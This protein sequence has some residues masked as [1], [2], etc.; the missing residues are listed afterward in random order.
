MKLARENG[1]VPKEIYSEK[2][3][4]PEDAIL[5]Q[6]L[7]Y[8]IAWQPRRPLLVASVDAAQCYNR[9]AHTVASLT[10]RAY[11][12]RQTSVAS[13]LTPIQSMEYYLRTGFG[14]STT[15]SGGKEDPKQGSCQGN[16]AAP[17][18]WQQ[19]SSL[20][21]NGQKHAGHGTTIVAPILKK[22]HSQ[23]AILFVDDTNLWEGLGEDDDVAFTLEKGQQGVNSWEKQPSCDGRR[24]QTGQVLVHSAQD[25]ANKNGDWEYTKEK[26]ATAT[27]KTDEDQEELDNL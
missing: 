25:E 26:L 17:P 1:L 27:K 19:I 14:E 9:I 7:V 5:Q 6:V 8:A 10:L 15:Y 13:I 4:T 12:V 11:K 21:I 18:T 23:V 24:A 16:T 20:L 2:G 22:S 3:K